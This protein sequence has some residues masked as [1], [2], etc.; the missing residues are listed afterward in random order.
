MNNVLKELQKIWAELGAN[1][2]ISLSAALLFVIGISVSLLVWSSRPNLQLLYG[3]LEGNDMSEVVN[4]L[5]EKGIQY[6]IKS[7]GSAVYVPSDKIYAVRMELAAKGVPHGGTVGFEIFDQSNF[8]ISDFVQRT[9]Y[10]RAIQG[11]LAR[12]IMQV[13]GVSSARVMIVIPENKL[14]AEANKTKPTASVFIDTG[15]LTLG[16]EAVNSIRFLVS[17][18]VEGMN[19]NDVAVIDNHG[20]ALSED[21]RTQ[22]TFGQASS[23][24]KFQ[25]SVENYY[26][27]KVESM[28][29]K[30]VGAGNVVARVSVEVDNDTFT[31]AEEIYNPESQVVRSQTINENTASSQKPTS[32]GAAGV[33][34]NTP[35]GEAGKSVAT[36]DEVR[37]SK[38][39]AYEI[40][41]TKTEL[42]R[43]P[44]TIKDITAAVFIAPKS[45]QEGS[46]EATLTPRTADEM[47]TIRLMVANALGLSQD[48]IVSNKVTV[49]EMPFEAPLIPK[50]EGIESMSGS[51]MQYL[52]FGKHFFAVGLAIL[53]FFIFLR[54]LKKHEPKS[55]SIE[56]MD[57]GSSGNSSNA[58]NVTPQPTPEFLNQLIQ[59]KPENISTALKNWVN[60]TEQQS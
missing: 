32:G 34:A 35:G 19:L 21:L 50:Q 40:N 24:M 41:K 13:K 14:L 51:V 26:A 18:A 4:L 36:N 54:M 46:G 37:K 9:N 31:Q 15:G 3:R 53:M 5:E 44:G 10:N 22:G 11:E 23:Q 56:I 60:N 17:S 29:V 6:E 7:G 57:S 48:D 12:T 25:E 27:K 55:L 8:G 59:Q 20:N 43:A 42:V 2:K 1:Q 49:E 45:T 39:I 47:K 58:K 30:I 16:R 38:T 33:Q 28:L 52:E